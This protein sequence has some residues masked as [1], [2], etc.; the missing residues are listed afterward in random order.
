MTFEA[1]NTDWSDAGA[2]LL[3]PDRADPCW[4]DHATLAYDDDLDED[5]SYF[6]ETDDEEDD[7]FEDDADEFDDEDDE[8]VDTDSDVDDDD[9]L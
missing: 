9:D 2:A 1:P 6:L 5:E 4:S 8:E 3:V 7:E